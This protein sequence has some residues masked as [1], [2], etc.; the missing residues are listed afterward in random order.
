MAA[1]AVAVAAARTR[2]RRLRQRHLVLSADARVL[3]LVEGQDGERALL[4]PLYDFGGIFVGVEAVHQHQRDRHAVLLVQVLD[5]AHGEV[6]EGQARAHFDDALRALAAHR[7][8]E[9][10]V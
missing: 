1:V 10:A 5:L 7:R 6:E 2:V 9:A 3:V 8:A 4:V